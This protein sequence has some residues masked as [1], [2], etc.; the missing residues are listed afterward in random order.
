M[1]LIFP[2]V[3]SLLPVLAC[4]AD[5]T[6]DMTV[7]LQNGLTGKAILDGMPTKDDPNCDK[8]VPLTLETAVERVLITPLNGDFAV[9]PRGDPEPTPAQQIQSLAR[10]ALALR[11]RANPKA[12][13]LHTDELS[14]ITKRI[15]IGY[16]G[17]VTAYVA[18]ML[19]D[20][21]S[22]DLTMPAKP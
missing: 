18:L 10:D 13:V 8:C 22:P 14:L 2:I 5:R 15:E 3:L 12:F 17:T 4:A 7:T 11:V 1:R 9:G 19:L 20:P 16:F 21:T 6:I